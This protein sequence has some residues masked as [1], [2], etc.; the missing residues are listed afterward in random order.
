MRFIH[1]RASARTDR[2]TSRTCHCL[3]RS[4]CEATNAPWQNS[5]GRRPSEEWTEFPISGTL[6][7]LSL[8]K[9]T[10]RRLPISSTE[11][12]G[13][14]GYRKEIPD[15][16]RYAS[17]TN[18]GKRLPAAS[19]RFS[20]DCCQFREHPI[21][22]RSLSGIRDFAA[23][24]PYFG[25]APRRVTNRTRFPGSPMLRSKR[26]AMCQ[27][28]ETGPPQGQAAMRLERLF[29]HGPLSWP[30]QPIGGFRP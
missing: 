22:A 20:R 4:C 16:R 7:M 2:A 8:V 18:I 6:V 28:A 9:K 5:Q 25:Q 24:Q 10:S 26:T 13:F 12:G 23:E 17:S 21:S 14:R 29:E 27:I 19:G 15:G 11:C 3:C 1:R 30:V